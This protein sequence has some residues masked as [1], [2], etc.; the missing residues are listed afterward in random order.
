M[1]N[2]DKNCVMA[3]SSH[4]MNELEDVSIDDWGSQKIVMPENEL[5]STRVW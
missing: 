4:N 5:K 2:K 3:T 1:H